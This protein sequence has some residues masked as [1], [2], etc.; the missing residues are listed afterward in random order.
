MAAGR[1]C[2]ST[3]TSYYLAMRLAL[4]FHFNQ[5]TSPFVGI[6]N[7]ACYRGLLEVLR[8]H[9]HLKINLH[10][11]G[12]LLRALP[13]F[14][15]ETLAL[16]R[17]GLADG[18]FELLGSTYAQNVPYAC[19][20]W[21]NAQQAALHRQVLRDMFGV[22][23]AAF[24]I[25]ERSWRQTL[26]PVIV[27][28]GHSVTLVE[29]HILHTAGLE[30]PLPCA[31]SLD[32]QSLTVVYDDT[33]LRHRFNFA[34]W[35][36][37]RAQL[38]RYLKN[39][40]ERPGSDAF[41]LAY[42]EDA[43]AM[44]LWPWQRGYLPHA[45]WTH[46]DALLGELESSSMVTLCHLSEARPERTVPELPDGAADWMDRALLDPNA[47]YHE[48]GYA[49]WYDFLQR[50]PKVAYFRRLHNVIRS[51]LKRLGAARA[52][53]G[54]TDD[55]SPGGRFYRQAVEAFCH[56]QY[57]FGCIGVGGRGYWGWENARSA[58]T[59]VRAAE[60]A[61]DTR[62]GQWIEDMTGDGSDEQILCDGRHL[63]IVTGY[64]GRLIYWLDLL[65]GRQLVGNHL[66]VPAGRY[67]T[68][69]TKAPHPAPETDRSLPEAF[70]AGLRVWQAQKQKEPV[71][72]GMARFLP[73]WIF[74]GEPAELTLYRNP[75]LPAAMARTPLNAQTGVF[76][77]EIS[78]DGRPPTRADE[79]LDFRFEA[80][81]LSYLI[82]P[83]E[84]VFVEKHISQA[85][86]SL[87]VRYII[88]NRDEVP[89]RVRLVSQH[90]LCP[91]YAE[92]LGRGQEA[93][94]YSLHQA[95]YPAVRNN[96]TGAVLSLEPNHDWVAADCGLNL[97]ALQA[98]LT[99]DFEIAPRSQASLEIRLCCSY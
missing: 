81:G 14:D 41:V 38:Q 33:I 39:V 95:R 17:A 74:E 12:T 59:F 64:G 8:A 52:A 4:V 10:L 89:H 9:P 31:T 1:D 67:E 75:E 6:A 60:L 92:A 80:G 57:E 83:S 19:D 63:A 29:D 65:A 13:W 16:V 36:G 93:F 44:G 54:A 45:A 49:D 78:V 69:T 70:K 46:L 43:E 47:P 85:D 82:F 90:E 91:D 23:P 3:I 30:D 32:G 22:E 20:D 42:A 25:S 98:T 2:I 21:D 37:R 66:A 51:R 76:A 18:Q 24:W 55:E 72:T 50:S 61:A 58:F 40:A 26:L 99:F 27:S 88:D 94:T 71:P 96:F 28:S 7:R 5:H 53:A 86:L 48:D 56:H 34:A 68:G 62:P 97:L 87:A 73:A 79:L 15:S 77:E 35:F 84:T 11:S